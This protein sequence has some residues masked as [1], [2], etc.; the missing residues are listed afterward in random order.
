MR[1]SGLA[2][3]TSR[4]GEMTSLANVDR[5]TGNLPTVAA[6]SRAWLSM[7]ASVALLGVLLIAGCAGTGASGDEYPAVGI[8]PTVSEPPVPIL[9]P[10]T[11]LEAESPDDIMR[12]PISVKIE[13]HG[14]ARP[15]TGLNQA[16]IVYET[17]AE[18]GITRFNCVYQSTIPARLGPVRSARLSDMWLVPQYDG[19]FFFSGANDQVLGRIS[20]DD[21]DDMSHS[22]ASSLYKRSSDRSAPHNLYLETEGLYDIAEDKGFPITSVLESLEFNQ[23]EFISAAPNGTSLTVPIS[24]YVT[25]VWKWNAATGMYE[26]YHSSTPHKDSDG[27]PIAA[28]NV[29]VMWA[30]YTAQPELNKGS[31]TYDIG[32]GGTGQASIFVGGQRIDGTWEAERN[33]PPKFK[34]ASG[35]PILLNPGN[36][37]FEVPPLDIQIT[38]N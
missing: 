3:R 31:I 10:Y 23:V 16:D 18:G 14:E 5:A 37:W 4:T 8:E 24:N 29:V 15:Q 6:G 17:I 30:K 13:N 11:G 28:K 12:R 1:L 36:T 22:A 19:L 34:D 7:V 32:L 35:N 26:R 27:S 21:L 20:S 2:R 33:A 38:A 9:W 25:I